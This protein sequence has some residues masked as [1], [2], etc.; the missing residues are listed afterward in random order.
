LSVAS[1]FVRL[2]EVNKA[3]DAFTQARQLFKMGPRDH[4]AP[5]EDVNLVGAF[6]ELGY[7]DNAYE[8]LRSMPRQSNREDALG[9][10]ALAYAHRGEL[11]AAIAK[12]GEMSPRNFPSG[13]TASFPE[14]A[15]LQVRA[16]DLSGALSTITRLRDTAGKG[17]EPTTYPRFEAL[18]D[19]FKA[20]AAKM[21]AETL[22]ATIA[23]L[24]TPQERIAAYI[25]LATG[26]NEAPPSTSA[27][28]Q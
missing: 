17:N 25:G 8:V 13:G 20:A 24:K 6:A 26:I 4:D 21:D 22:D 7:F 23:E 15:L 2:N 19:V 9:L 27:S 18:R 10:I 16:G 5:I 3:K 28:S 1:A 12:L 11:Q 14:I